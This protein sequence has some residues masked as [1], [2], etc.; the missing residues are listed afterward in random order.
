MLYLFHKTLLKLLLPYLRIFWEFSSQVP[1]PFAA[2]LGVCLFALPCKLTETLT[3]YKATW[4]GKGEGDLIDFSKKEANE[5]DI[6]I[7]RFAGAGT[8]Q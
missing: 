1:I 2:L 4:K 7:A 5:N 6:C 3:E 8:G